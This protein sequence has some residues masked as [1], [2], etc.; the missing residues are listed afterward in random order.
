MARWSYNPNSIAEVQ[1]DILKMN[2]VIQRY[3]TTKERTALLTLD[4]WGP[5]YSGST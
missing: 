1:Y 2:D 3:L 5:N 4:L